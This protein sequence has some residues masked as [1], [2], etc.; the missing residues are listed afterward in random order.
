MCYH[1]RRTAP[2]APARGWRGARAALFAAVCCA[3]TAGTSGAADVTSTWGGGTGNWGSAPNW[4]N[5]PPVNHFPNNGNGGFT[6]D[7]VINS[8]TVTL[9]QNIAIQAFTLGSG[10]LTG[11][12]D[13]T[14]AALL[15][16]NSGTMSGTG[17]TNANGGLA[18]GP[19]QATLSGR[20]LNNAAAAT[21]G[22]GGTLFIQTGGEFNN[23]VGASFEAQGES[24]IFGG[25]TPNGAFNNSGSF[26]KVGAGETQV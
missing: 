25:G 2:S 24:D 8:G 1:V 23:L 15:T 5:S 18:L 21:L 9:N 16:W 26:R 7:A 20:T 3:A 13:L 14:T 4:S 10:T 19:F 12:N 11:A 22:G 17:V 6:Y